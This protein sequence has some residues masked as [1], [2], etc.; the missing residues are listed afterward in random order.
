MSEIQQRPE[1][2]AFASEVARRA[3]APRSRAER[4]ASTVAYHAGPEIGFTAVVGGSGAILVHPAALPIVAALTAVW[5]AVDR[6][7]RRRGGDAAPVQSARTASLKTSG[8][9]DKSDE[10]VA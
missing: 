6:L 5:V 8:V 2:V 9:A 1:P 7:G 3:D 10:G 4:L